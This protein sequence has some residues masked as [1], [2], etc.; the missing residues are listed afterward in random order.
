MRVGGRV[1]KIFSP[2]RFPETRL[3]FFAPTCFEVVLAGK[4]IKRW[5]I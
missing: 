4:L 3:I 1:I 5:V 2:C